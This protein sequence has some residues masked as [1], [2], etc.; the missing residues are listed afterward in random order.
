MKN[1]KKESKRIISF[2]TEFIVKSIDTRKMSKIERDIFYKELSET[3]QLC[4]NTLQ[5]LI[6]KW[7]K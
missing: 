4:A 7:Y 3:T 1:N 6:S 2:Y 5:S